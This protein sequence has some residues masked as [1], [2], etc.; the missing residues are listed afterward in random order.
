ML[1]F[2][3]ETE[4]TQT[5]IDIFANS[6]NLKSELSEYIIL[7][8]RDLMETFN[9]VEYAYTMKVTEK[10]DIYSYGVVL[11]EL[12]TGKAPVQP[13]DQGGDVVSWV[14]SYIRR[15]ALSS[16]VL[17]ARLKLEDERIVSHMLNVLKIALLCTS[18]SPVARPSMRQVVLMLIES[19]RQEGDEHTDTD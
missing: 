17:D 4:L 18:V 12:L 3:S 16:G 2:K 19:D 1:V 11:L 15:D 5:K 8:D 7:I 13:I 9:F 6:K 10:S 14:R